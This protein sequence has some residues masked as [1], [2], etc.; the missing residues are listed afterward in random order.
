MAYAKQAQ[1]TYHSEP[2]PAT[3]F[4]PHLSNLRALSLNSLLSIIIS[5]K[6]LYFH[7]P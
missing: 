1:D 6:F 4:G 2:T 5:Y 7:P 3:Q